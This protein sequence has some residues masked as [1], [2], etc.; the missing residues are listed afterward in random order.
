[1][2]SMQSWFGIKE[3]HRDFSIEN[4]ADSRLFF[5]RHDLNVQLMAILKRS[6]RTGNP[7]KMVLYGDWGVG[8][9]HTMRHIQYVLETRG[10]D[11]PATVVFVELPDIAGKSTFHVA[12]AGLLDAL[13]IDRAREWVLKY[14][15]I[16]GG[17]T[18]EKIQDATQ[19][20][21]IAM[22]FESLLGYGES[23]RIAWDWLRG[24]SLNAGDARLVGLPSVMDQ[25]N[26]LVRTLQM[27]GRLCQAAE[28]KLLVFMLDEATKLMF[29]SNAD[30]INHWMNAFKLIAD[31]QSKE[32][33]FIVS[34]SWVDPDDMAMPLQDP[35]VMSRFGESNYI[36]LTNL[37]E[38]S[39]QEF[40]SALLSEWVDAT[41][42]K[43]IIDRHSAEADGEA[44]NEGTYPFTYEGLVVA[45][46]YACRNGGITTPRDIQK[47]VD[48]LLNRAI[49]D[50]RH[51]VS[52]RYIL[53]LIGA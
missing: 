51:I 10:D 39:T 43:Q 6:F 5:A 17:A 15:T 29:V 20:G 50:G 53:S 12:H 47:M 16:H 48:D 36:R 33:G 44:V 40:L 9:T 42:R 27:L 4:D 32:V 28:E 2:E 41:L 1:M 30:A 22:A 37:D 14:R 8:K 3:G 31:S 23:G 52:S 46:Q 18:R 7:P 38:Q 24:V 49:D 26:Q 13:G 11:F 21:D 34:G 35:Q 25:S 45:A 19:S